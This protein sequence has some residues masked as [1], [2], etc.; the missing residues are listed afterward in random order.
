VW[1]F[2]IYPTLQQKYLIIRRL[3][4]CSF[5]V[6]PVSTGYGSARLTITFLWF[7]A[8]PHHISLFG[9]SIELPTVNKELL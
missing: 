4:K 5:A 3:L 6:A 9:F 7:G 1:R 8:A 2:Y